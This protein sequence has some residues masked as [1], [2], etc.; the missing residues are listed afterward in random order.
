MQRVIDFVA[1]YKVFI[2]FITLVIISL[3]L[4][5]NGNVSRIGG[6]RT[7][8][9]GTIGWLQELFSWLPNPGALQSE[10][11]ALRKLN[12]QL[13]AEVTRMR[14][15][16]IENKKLREML[17]FEERNERG[18]I[19]SEIA[20]RTTIEL[21]RYFTL[22]KGTDDGVQ[23]G[24]AVRSP[25]GLIGLIVGASDNYSLMELILNRNIRIAC[26][27]VRNDINGILFWGGGDDFFLKNIPESYDVKAGDRIITSNASNRYPKNI[28]IGQITNIEED[29]SSL[30][31]KVKVKPFVEFSTLQEVFI[32]KELPNPERL[33]LIE[34]ME[35]RLEARTK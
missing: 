2:T 1:R 32:I 31:L 3:S 28:P 34:E 15:S 11:R 5:S 21:R 23:R 13:S 7:V 30:F 24:M 18:Y 22:N 26:K 10:N 20:G 8:V 29:P 16:L 27:V 19:T 12:L 33:K 17:E 4:I 25:A 9:I 35:E 14:H 6:F